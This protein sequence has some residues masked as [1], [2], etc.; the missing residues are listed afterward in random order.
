MSTYDCYYLKDGNARSPVYVV[1]ANDAE[2]LLRAEELLAESR[3]ITMEVRQA[4]RLVGYVTLGSP[5]ALMGGEGSGHTP[6]PMDRAPDR[7]VPPPEAPTPGTT[8]K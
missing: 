8:N 6:S 1:A 3:S 5:A 4:D 7:R 2:A